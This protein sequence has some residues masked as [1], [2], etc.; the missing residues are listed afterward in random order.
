MVWVSM[1]RIARSG[2]ISCDSCVQ[3]G[4]VKPHEINFGWTAT[5]LDFCGKE[6]RSTPLALGAFGSPL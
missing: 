3:T 6:L 2:A 4:L 5:Y 1:V